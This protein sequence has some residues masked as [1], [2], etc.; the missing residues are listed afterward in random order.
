ILSADHIAA[1]PYSEDSRRARRVDVEL[2]A[3]AWKSRSEQDARL[4]RCVRA[5]R[6]R[7]LKARQRT[8]HE[9]TSAPPDGDY[10]D[11]ELF[12]AGNG[13]HAVRRLWLR[14]GCAAESRLHA[15]EAIFEHARA[16]R[17]FPDLAGDVAGGNG[18]QG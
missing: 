14:S 12:R 7:E 2:H 4:F 13:S 6:L 15:L 16:R 11:S 10:G 17:R 9:R 3:G 1:R 5:N 8:V 18:S